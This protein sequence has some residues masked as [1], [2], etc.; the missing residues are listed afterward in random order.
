MS[1]ARVPWKTMLDGESK[2]PWRCAGLQGVRSL[3]AIHR[4]AVESD[5]I[6]TVDFIETCNDG[7]R[8]NLRL[9]SH[10]IWSYP[11]PDLGHRARC[12]SFSSPFALRPRPLICMPQI[13]ESA[14]IL[15]KVTTSPMRLRRP[16][17]LLVVGLLALC[18]LLVVVV[19]PR[20]LYF[21]PSVA[22]LK[23][24]LP[25]L[26]K[27]PI[28]GIH[29]HRNSQHGDD[30]IVASYLKWVESAG[31]RGVRIPYNATTAEL[32]ELLESVNGVLFPGGSGD[33]N[34]AATYIYKKALGLN[35]NGTY[36]PLW[37]TCLGF[38][39]LIELQAEDSSIL[40]KVDA[41]N[42]SSTLAF[43]QSNDASRLL[44]FSHHF[45]KLA[46]QGIA[47]NFHN[48]GILQSHFDATP[49]LTSFYKV[50][51]TSED[52]QG[53]TYVAAIEA[54]DV[55]FY[56][57]QFHPE[58]NPY[59]LGDDKTGGAM[60]LV[61]HSYEAIVISQEFA[62]FFVGEARRNGNHFADPAKEAA[63]LLLN[64]HTSNR[65]YPYFEETLLFPVN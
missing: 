3:L 9:P 54:F 60:N 47:A 41:D 61:D 1:R 20:P 17:P 7:D 45:D 14:P 56:A 22:N 39:W 43:Q 49:K 30:F 21:A 57:V 29:A 40:D 12:G 24:T 19:V 6:P 37:G 51:A 65:S 27:N 8:F 64:A 16:F 32:D 48:Y 15:F 34:D 53:L 28:I 13:A 11:T 23:A 59:E 62:H 4:W 2:P 33:P 5:A 38:E 26:T 31:G 10:G 58:K 55:P 35:R 36:F 25:I 42:I 44:S 52:R 50:L 63:L 18:T 46:T